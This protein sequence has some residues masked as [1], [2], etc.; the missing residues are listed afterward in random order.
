[1]QK[2]VVNQATV[3]S[4]EKAKMQVGHTATEFKIRWGNHQMSFTN[5]NRHN[6]TELSKI[7][8]V[9]KR[10]ESWFKISWQI[11]TSKD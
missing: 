3:T 8:M 6:D 9:I 7:P 4:K 10:C 5:E 2:P 11:L 1:M